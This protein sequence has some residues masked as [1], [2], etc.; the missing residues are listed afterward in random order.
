MRC[1]RV[2]LMCVAGGMGALVFA[3]ASILTSPSGEPTA[4]PP[5]NC[6]APAA[7]AYFHGGVMALGGAD[8]DDVAAYIANAVA[9]DPEL[10]A[11]WAEAQ[12]DEDAWRLFVVM[13]QAKAWAGGCPAAEGVRT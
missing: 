8:Q 4:V 9:F 12:N 13:L 10:A 2:L 3:V 6:Y 1:G 5:V 7:A 11:L